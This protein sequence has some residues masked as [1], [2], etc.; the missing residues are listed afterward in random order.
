MSSPEREPAPISEA[1]DVEGALGAAAS[2]WTGLVRMHAGTGDPVMLARLQHAAGNAETAKLLGELAPPH[3]RVGRQ[4]D[5][6]AA[7]GGALLTADDAG[8]PGVGRMTVSAFLDAVETDVTEVA[9]AE[10]GPMFEV[11]GCP[12][13]EHWISYYRQRTPGDVE[14]AL[15]RYAPEAATAKTASQYVDL[16][17]ARVREGITAWRTTGKTPEPP[18]DSPGA[19]P[20][21][22]PEPAFSLRAG[23]TRPAVSSSRLGGSLGSGERLDGALG[24]ELGSAYGADLSGVRVHTGGAA[25]RAVS[26]FGAR[27]VT[28]GR[29]IAFA[30]GEYEP[31]TAVGDA[32]IA[33]EVAHVVQQ[34]AP[35]LGA[36][37]AD[38]AALEQDA[39]RAAIDA[40]M[41]RNGARPPLRAASPFRAQTCL[42]PSQKTE[43]EL[44]DAEAEA[45][46]KRYHVELHVAP[47][48]DGKSAP[49]GFTPRFW[50]TSPEGRGPRGDAPMHPVKNWYVIKPRSSDVR[51]R[52]GPEPGR[53][54]AVEMDEVGQWVVLA[55]FVIDNKKVYVTRRFDIVAGEAIIGDAFKSADPSDYVNY[56]TLM[57]QERLKRAGG[58]DID[59]SKVASAYITNESPGAA[60]PAPVAQGLESFKYKVHPNPKAPPDKKPATYRWWAIPHDT[61]MNKWSDRTDLGRRTDYQGQLAFY[62]GEGE[63]RSFRRHGP[64]LIELV[65]ECIDAGGKLVDT[66]V[67]QQRTMDSIGLAE[68]RQV[69]KMMKE[70]AADYRK[71]KPGAAK[72]V[73]ASYLDSRRGQ[74]S[75]LTMFIGPKAGDEKRVMLV[76]LTP[77][78]EYVE[79]EGATVEAAIKHLDDNN[80]YGDGQLWI[81]VEG[82]PPV[83]K[84][85]KTTGESDLQDAAQKTGIGSMVLMGIGILAAATGVGTIA[86]PFLIAGMGVGAVSGGLSIADELRKAKPSG[87]KIAVDA[88]GIVGALAG[89]GGV[90]QAI[91]MGSVELA[92]TTAAGRFFIYTGFAFDVTGG[93]LIAADTAEKIEE[94]RRSKMTE[95]EKID[96]IQRLVLQLVVVGGFIVFGSR[97]VGAAKARVLKLVGEER[98]GK[99]PPHTLYTL[100][101]L[102]DTVLHALQKVPVNEFEAVATALSKDPRRAAALSKAFK[103]KFIDEVRVNPAR[104]LD[105][106]AEV[107]GA[108]AAG[109]PVG[110]TRGLDIYQLDASRGLRGKSEAARKRFERGVNSARGDRLHGAKIEKSSLTFTDDV[111]QLEMTVGGQQIKVTVE[112]K[113]TAELTGGAHPRTGD[114]GPGRIIQLDAPKG[115]GKH[116]TAKV[117][118]D[119]ALL[120]ENVP[121]V[122][123]HELDEIADFVVTRGAGGIRTLG[124]EMEAGLF[125]SWK[126]T[127]GSTTPPAVTSHDRAAAR[128]LLNVAAD[129]ADINRTLLLNPGDKVAAAKR[130][131]RQATLDKLM[132]SMGLLD[133]EHIELK[134]AT[135]RKS[136]ADMEKDPKLALT[137]P[138]GK[139]ESAPFQQ[140]VDAVQRGVTTAEFMTATG[141]VA[142]GRTALSPDL[143]AHVIR[144]QPQSRHDFKASGLHGG[145]HQAALDEFLAAH[146]EYVMVFKHEAE[147]GG[148]KYTS[149]QQYRWNTEKGPP[150]P[151]GSPGRPDG[152]AGVAIDPN[153]EPAPVKFPKTTFSDADAFLKSADSIITSWQ[154]KFTPA[155]LANPMSGRPTVI[156][157]STPELLVW[158]DYTPAAGWHIRAVAINEPW[159]AAVETA[160]KT[161]TPPPAGVKK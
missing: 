5:A 64:A 21:L 10:L 20:D 86:A 121:F 17:V 133:P 22:A 78:A 155:E 97:D 15:R 161:P 28:V 50:A 83:E 77:G 88:A 76:D 27:A 58:V 106:T 33:H 72:G 26:S 40:A 147:S 39:D 136:F 99:L 60:N 119:D 13:L 30:P 24:G 68:V 107:L 32:L 71:I 117:E 19:P 1:Q 109:A 93:V 79:H 103:E 31:G 112:L 46:A 104:S 43:G 56:R 142:G 44:F 92:M 127:R 61:D 36:G 66:A 67:Y 110:G 8:D 54:F 2:D 152:P 51:R 158:F 37:T 73:K 128:E 100:Q 89:A 111:A 141:A 18:A 94:I 140:L 154:G 6:D 62:L 101:A 63:Q 25:A 3:L 113:K 34:T 153:W 116:W 115:G 150:P 91:R 130:P 139:G 138:I 49:V 85:L 65:C 9:A 146:P 57:N 53:R 125:V 29:D 75:S 81:R 157:G 95:D 129:L 52:N 45:L 135:L 55:Q 160:A 47:D 148:V 96:A 69:D 118:L 48:M 16:V 70:A 80:S 122:L 82:T 156:P 149:Y 41:A 74:T 23:S 131:N 59:Q 87:T 143:V 124:A 35:T 98:V 114:P 159:I 14:D 42:P 12:W 123:G 105:E 145:H 4:A 134:M 151:K 137:Q 108:R 11:T 102:D 90:G 84:R 7:P 120:L 38:T 132:K 126:T 144:A